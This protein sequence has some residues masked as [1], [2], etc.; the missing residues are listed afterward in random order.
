MKAWEYEYKKLH[1]AS[2]VDFEQNPSDWSGVEK[3]LKTRQE[4]LSLFWSSHV[5]GSRAPES[6]Y[7]AMVYP[8]FKAVLIATSE[9]AQGLERGPP[10]NL[11]FLTIEQNVLA[12]TSYHD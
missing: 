11:Y 10:K 4:L 1:T 2:P 3:T 5:P 8:V 12:F 7:L 9:V 6:M